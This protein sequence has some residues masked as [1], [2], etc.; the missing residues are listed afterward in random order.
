MLGSVVSI[1][2]G[3]QALGQDCFTH[4]NSQDGRHLVKMVDDNWQD[5]NDDNL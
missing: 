5:S 4:P 3:L 2:A 1:R